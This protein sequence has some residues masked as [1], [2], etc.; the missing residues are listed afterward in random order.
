MPEHVAGHRLPEP[1]DED[2]P[3]WARAHHAHLPAQHVHELRHLVQA[4]AAEEGAEAHPAGIIGGSPDRPRLGLG[5]H[6]HGAELQHAEALAVEPHAL[7]AEEHRPVRRELDAGGD[8]RQQRRQA[9]EHRQREDDVEGALGNLAPAVERRL[10]QVDEGHALELLHAA[11]E[12]GEA[13]EIGHHVDRHRLIA[14]GVQ[15]TAEP[16]LILVTERQHHVVHRPRVEHGAQ[17]RVAA[18]PRHAPDLFLLVPDA[19]EDLDADVPP[20]LDPSHDGRRQLAAPHDHRVPEVVAVAAR[21]AQRLAE[22]RAREPHGGDGQEPEA[23]DDDTRVV[24]AAEEEGHDGHEDEGAQGR[25]LG[26]VGGLGEMGADA[27]R[28][29]EI[30]GAEGHP[31]DDEDRQQHQEV[32]AEGW[33][34]AAQERRAEHAEADE[35]GQEPASR[36]QPEVA[37]QHELLEE[38]RVGLQHRPCS[39]SRASR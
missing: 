15:Q 26:D 2:R 32:G 37:G 20:R 14:D 36:H 29:V 9:D 24:V 6:P 12:R 28:A 13:E 35:I 30:E 33:D 23:D 39:A 8:E 21:E 34:V 7:L 1:L 5:V 22:R 4:E 11:P 19:P 25:G 10:A 3:L 27:P 17:V 31:P 38:P 18:Q 16:P